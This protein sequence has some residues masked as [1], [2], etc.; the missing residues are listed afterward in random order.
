MNVTEHPL[1][2]K[3]TASLGGAATEGAAL[4]EVSMDAAPKTIVEAIN[5]FIAD[6]P[7][8]G[9][10]KVDYWEERAL[11]L[12]C[13]WAAQMIR[14]FGWTWAT[15]IQHDHADYKAVGLFSPD[16]SLAI[17]PFHYIYGCFENKVY[18]A[19]L[20]AFNMLKDGKIPALPPKG[21]INLMD[22]VRH[23]VPPR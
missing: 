12:G 9:P 20:L 3:I 16:R 7:A 11:P 6:P 17:Y 1:D 18:P 8:D 13:L 23:V 14:E 2:P 10:A 15:V 4:L 19:I 5:A 22:G 21:Y